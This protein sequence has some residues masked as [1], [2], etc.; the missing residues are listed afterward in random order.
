[1]DLCLVSNNI[2]NI[3][4]VK[5]SGNTD[6]GKTK[7]MFINNIVKPYICL[8]NK[9]KEAFF[10]IISN[11][12]DC[13][14]NGD[15]TGGLSKYMKPELILVENSLFDLVLPDDVSFSDF[16]NMVIIK[17]NQ[18]KPKNKARSKGGK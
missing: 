14:K 16:Q 18:N 15:W 11:N 9:P 5:S 17:A 8:E 10:G 3:I 13:N 6:S 4:E 12:M 2:Y 7:H 1:M